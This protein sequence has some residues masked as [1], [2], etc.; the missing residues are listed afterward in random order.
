MA[1]SPVW[2]AH[3]HQRC[4]PPVVVLSKNAH[5]HRT[6]TLTSLTLSLGLCPLCGKVPGHLDSC[7]GR[8]AV[9]RRQC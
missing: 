2:P 9:D 8:E 4:S 3:L 5:P 6:Y 1:I 7:Y